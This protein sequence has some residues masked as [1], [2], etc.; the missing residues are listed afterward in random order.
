MQGSACPSWGCEKGARDLFTPCCAQRRGKKHKFGLG[1]NWGFSRRSSSFGANSWPQP[2]GNPCPRGVGSQE[3]HLKSQ[4]TAG[5]RGEP[6]AL[7]LDLPIPLATRRG[8][9]CHR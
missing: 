7:L 6:R 2:G 4:K 3:E 5:R 8:V 1:M 9:R